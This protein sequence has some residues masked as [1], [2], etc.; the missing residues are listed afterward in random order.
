MPTLQDDRATHQFCRHAAVRASNVTAL[1]HDNE[2]SPSAVGDDV[3]DGQHHHDLPP[4]LQKIDFPRF[5]GKTN[6]LIFVNRCESYF[7]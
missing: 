5:D 3:P 6:P 7:H 1:K 2:K 4:K